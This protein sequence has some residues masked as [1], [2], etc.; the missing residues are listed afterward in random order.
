MG[1]IG[2]TTHLL[3]MDPNYFGTSKWEDVG[4]VEGVETA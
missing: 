4:G 2:F 3:T 1:Y